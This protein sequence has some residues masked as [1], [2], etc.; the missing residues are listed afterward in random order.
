LPLLG[1]YVTEQSENVSG[2]RRDF[3]QSFE[4]LRGQ[5]GIALSAFIESLRVDL[6]RGE[7][8]E[9]QPHEKKGSL[10][11]VCPFLSLKHHT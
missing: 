4:R 9:A 7:G 2:L 5:R 6:G 1:L 8:K 3:Q 10:K 11:K